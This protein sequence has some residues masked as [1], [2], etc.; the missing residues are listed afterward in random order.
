MAGPP[1]EAD[2]ATPEKTFLAADKCRDGDDVIRIRG[3]LQAQ[4]KAQAQDREKRGFHFS[5]I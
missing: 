1:K 5:A 2:P 3:V 4:K